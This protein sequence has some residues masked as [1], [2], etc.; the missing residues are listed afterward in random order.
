MCYTWFGAYPDHMH[1]IIIIIII[2]KNNLLKKGNERKR[3]IQKKNT[4]AQIGT[5]VRARGFNAGLLA[6]SQFAS[7]RS[8]DRP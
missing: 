2:V 8:C 4:T 5:K 3:K 1:I 6:R 7:G